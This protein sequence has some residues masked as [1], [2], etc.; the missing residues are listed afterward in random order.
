MKKRFVVGLLV[1]LAIAMLQTPSYA[2]PSTKYSTQTKWNIPLDATLFDVLILRPMGIAS[3]VLG[4]ATSVVAMPF[5]ITSGGGYE[6]GDK[7][8]TEPIEYTFKRPV[9]YDY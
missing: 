3:C 2:E 4:I 8:I 9:G 6:V 7:L 1:L 5:V